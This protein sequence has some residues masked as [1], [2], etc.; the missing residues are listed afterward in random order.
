MGRVF[1]EIQDYSSSVEA[2]EKFADLN[3]RQ[4]HVLEELKKVEY[5]MENVTAR[6]S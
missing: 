1:C 4:V 6:E 5:W 2:I 3:I